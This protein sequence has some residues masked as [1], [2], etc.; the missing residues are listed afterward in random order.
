[1]EPAVVWGDEL[2]L[3]VERVDRWIQISEIVVIYP[4]SLLLSVFSQLNYLSDHIPNPKQTPNTSQVQIAPL[5]RKLSDFTPHQHSERI[6]W[7]HKP[8]LLVWNVRK[9]NKVEEDGVGEV[10][11]LVF[12]PS[13]VDVIE[14]SESESPVE[15]PEALRDRISNVELLIA[16][17]K[18]LTE[19]LS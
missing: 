11:A 18:V 13:F 6:D 4:A 9:D 3:G 16:G 8:R 14:T 15:D 12:A 2:L 10:R 5:K 1:M 19:P 7:Q 17:A